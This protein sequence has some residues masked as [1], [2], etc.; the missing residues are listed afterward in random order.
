MQIPLVYWYVVDDGRDSVG[1]LDGFLT[2]YRDH[3]Q[4]VVVKNQGAGRI[5]PRSR[6]LPCLTIPIAL[7]GC[8]N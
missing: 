4:C 7:A 8:V 2:K 5:S 6:D 1:L 3:L